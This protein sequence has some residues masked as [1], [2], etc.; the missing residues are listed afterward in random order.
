MGKVNKYIYNII[1]SG[2]GDSLE[3]SVK[4]KVILI[5]IILIILFFIFVLFSILNYY[6]F[7]LLLLTID[8]IS[9]FLVIILFVLLRATLMLDAVSY[10]LI[11]TFS[12]EL[13]FFLI[14]GGKE[15][16]GLTY[17]LL[18]PTPVFFILGKRKGLIT[19]S[20]FSLAAFFSYLLFMNFSWFPDYN[21]LYLLRNCTV[22]FFILFF[23]YNYEYAI[24]RTYYE[25]GKTNMWLA[26]SEEQYRT[27]VENTNIGIL[28]TR[29]DK[30]IF[31]NSFFTRLTGHKKKDL[32]G[33]NVSDIFSQ[34]DFQ[35]GKNLLRSAH[36]NDEIPEYIESTVTTKAGNLI[37]VEMNVLTIHLHKESALL[38]TVNDI[39]K[40]KRAE[41]EKEGL[42][43]QLNEILAMKDRFI[44]VLAH[45]LKGPLGSYYEF[46][47]FF[48]DNYDEMT[49]NE[50]KD[51]INSIK[52][53]SKNN[54]D[55]LLN[56][57]NWVRIQ[58]NNMQFN[59][60]ILSIKEIVNETTE[61]Y[62]I[63]AE[64]KNIKIISNIS[65]KL[66]AFG[67]LD[68]IYIVM[69]NLVSNS[70]KFSYDGGTIR[71][72]ASELNGIVEIQVVDNGKGVKSDMLADIFNLDIYSRGKA[73][74][75]KMS[76]GLGLVLCKEM[77]ERNGG[78]IWIE[79]IEGK[80][81]TTTFTLPGDFNEIA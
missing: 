5:N 65:P 68:M 46:M 71:I 23:S 38:V 2:K 36:A 78:Q 79:S 4:R 53:S 72:I 29:S 21:N 7:N 76:T 73:G 33:K 27:L 1:T 15:N 67:D 80:G 35:K 81:T 60:E 74:S 28:I 52:I 14:T 32:E 55:L 59:P 11:I 44:S 17:F 50:K 64:R 19:V 61:F 58:N 20:I 56:L 37:S 62:R 40:R 41:K 39:S 10:L 16:S 34:D 43:K 48:E 24:D 54:Y 12:C 45:D 22:Y 47:E 8:T 57:L 51:I 49:D 6:Y 77:V 25:L 9:I 66:Y 18:Y 75:G 13:I 3:F 70:I 69:R 63:E 31:S 42:I 26:D 30:V